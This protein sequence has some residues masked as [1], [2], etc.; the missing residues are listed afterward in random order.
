MLW[1]KAGLDLKSYINSYWFPYSPGSFTL[2]LHSTPKRFRAYLTLDVESEALAIALKGMGW[3]FVE[4]DSQPTASYLYLVL[5]LFKVTVGCILF[6]KRGVLPNHEK[7]ILIFSL[8]E[9]EVNLVRICAIVI[10]K[11]LSFFKV[12]R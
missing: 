12:S 2:P 1:E 6:L 3:L 11:R 9:Y 10:I 5:R 8:H 4:A 7:I